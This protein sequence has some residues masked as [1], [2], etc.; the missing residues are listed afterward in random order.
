MIIR[1]TL[2]M[3]MLLCLAT[4]AF[5]QESTDEKT[6]TDAQPKAEYVLPACPTGGHG[7]DLAAAGDGVWHYDGAW[8]ALVKTPLTAPVVAWSEEAAVGYHSPEPMDWGEKPVPGLGGVAWDGE[9]LW[10]LDTENRRIC[11][12]EKNT[13]LGSD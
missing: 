8:N 5:A 7:T 9:N 12:T 10:V 1:L 6:K 3:L 4:S 13:R 11:I 2:P